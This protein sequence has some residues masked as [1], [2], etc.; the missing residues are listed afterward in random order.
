M[1]RLNKKSRYLTPSRFDPKRQD[2]QCRGW[3]HATDEYPFI[4][5]RK[6]RFDPRS[7]RRDPRYTQI[8][9]GAALLEHIPPLE[10]AVRGELAW[11]LEGDERWPATP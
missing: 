1:D 9:D 10:D 3:R 8:G 7:S 2:P 4:V 6:G 11:L 5:C